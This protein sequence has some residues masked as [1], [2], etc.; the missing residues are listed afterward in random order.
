DG[1]TVLASITTTGTSYANTDGLATGTYY[2]RINSY[3][4]NQFEPYTLTDS[5]FKPSQANDAEPDSSKATALTLPLNSTATGHVNYYYKNHRDSLDFYK[6][7]TD[8]DG[9]L[10]LK[11]TS[12]NG[13][14]V[15]AY[16]FDND[17]TT[18]LASV[19]TTGI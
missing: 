19:T 14:N 12:H 15:S 5:L 7:T 2:V 1:N 16:L 10:Q 3:Y 13:N 11:L 9:L 4:N 6:I 18:V 17:G 8:G